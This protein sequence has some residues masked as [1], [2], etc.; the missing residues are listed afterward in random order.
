MKKLITYQ[1]LLICIIVFLFEPIYA[2]VQPVTTAMLPD[3]PCGMANVPIV[4]NTETR[5]NCDA[6]SPLDNP[7]DILTAVV[8]D[9][10]D[11]NNGN[12]TFLYLMASNNSSTGG[13]AVY[14]AAQA[15]IGDGVAI[16]PDVAICKILPNN[17]TGEIF[18]VY[19]SNGMSAPNTQTGYYCDVFNYD[20]S[21]N[22]T[23]NMTT[24]LIQAT[25][26]ITNPCI[27]ID[28]DSLGHIGIV[29]YESDTHTFLKLG[30]LGTGA[31]TSMTSNDFFTD[32]N[33]Y[34]LPINQY[35]NNPS[36]KNIQMPDIAIG[37]D[38]NGGY[39]GLVSYIKSDFF[40]TNIEVLSFRNASNTL[41]TGLDITFNNSVID[42]ITNTILN[43]MPRIATPN[44]STNS[45]N[46]F[47]L[48]YE[49]FGGYFNQIPFTLV[50]IL[51]NS[52][53]DV[54]YAADVSNYFATNATVNTMPV[55][56][57]TAGHQIA[58]NWHYQF[59]P[60]PVPLNAGNHDYNGIASILIEDVSNYL[61][62][63]P[64]VGMLF[65]AINVNSNLSNLMPVCQE[66]YIGFNHQQLLDIDALA[67]ALSG[68]YSLNARACAAYI[69][70]VLAQPQA[71]ISASSSLYYKISETANSFPGFFW[72]S[73]SSNNE[74]SL[75]N[76]FSIFP[77]PS[78]SQITITYNN[79]NTNSSKVIITNMLGQ[80]VLEE[81]LVNK[82]NKISMD[83]SNLQD[84]NYII[85]LIQDGAI[86]ST[87]KFVKM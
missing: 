15:K 40:I 64:G 78:N 20:A 19:Y 65:P 45:L 59:M 80:N 36:F 8:T 71:G 52:K 16:G 1:I 29:W 87:Q 72:R 75:A 9:A 81:L 47:T 31:I 30:A 44:I 6:K 14:Q 10:Q 23:P 37:V 33:F 82:E 43:T 61:P 17:T 53:N 39:F 73:N 51:G 24:Y 48:V 77:N 25:S 74:I 76:G 21:G 18:V 54:P 49:R 58:I 27:N 67:S 55:L 7:D 26:T 84:G 79:S 38:I 22:L 46:E 62:N 5:V 35:A 4:P 85:Q 83:I 56:C 2:Q 57:Y 13:A 3:L 69:N 41:P 66:N 12:A 32:P 68:K 34:S 50:S 60:N 42:V 86:T 28:I 70:N 11:V 63:S